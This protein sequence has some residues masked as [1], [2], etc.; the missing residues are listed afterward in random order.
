M[1]AS[2]CITFMIY[3]PKK[4]IPPINC[5]ATTAPNAIT[6]TQGPLH[7]LR[8]A[9]APLPSTWT[10]GAGAG[11]GTGMRPGS[12][13]NITPPLRVAT[14]SELTPI[15]F[16]LHFP[17]VHL[18]FRWCSHGPGR[19]R[20][21]WPTCVLSGNAFAGNGPVVF[22]PRANR[23]GGWQ[24]SPHTDGDIPIGFITTRRHPVTRSDSPRP[25]R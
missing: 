19:L 13:R 14:S 15:D 4:M 25:A 21:R 8:A 16:P 7:S 18:P 11:A 22:R 20:R 9:R 1:R 17:T 12:F 24:R 5:N 2:S 6:T 10:H 3:T 23:R